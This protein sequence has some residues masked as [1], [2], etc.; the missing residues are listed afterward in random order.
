[1]AAAMRVELLEAGIW[2]LLPDPWH[3]TGD[4]EFA[5]CPRHTAKTSSTMADGK[6][7]TAATGMAKTLFAVCQ[8]SG[9]R[10]TFSLCVY[11][12]ARRKKRGQTLSRPADGVGGCSPCA[13][14]AGTR[15]RSQIRRVPGRQAHGNAARFA[16]C[17]DGR[18]T[19]TLPDS[20]CALTKGT[21]RTMVSS[22]CARP[23]HTA[24]LVSR[25]GHMVTLPCA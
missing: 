14:T 5:V 12:G 3:T 4:H 8:K 6:A 18:H 25:A 11:I 9:T 23:R 19:A 16:V 7:R 13:R 1:M 24:N 15:Q 17:P 2:S 10:Q 21:R 20:P 22:P